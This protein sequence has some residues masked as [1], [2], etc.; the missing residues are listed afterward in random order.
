M[1]SFLN[2]EKMIIGLTGKKQH[3]KDTV[4]D[5]LVENGFLKLSFADPLKKI[6]QQ[7]FSL[8][9]SQLHDPTMKEVVDP[10]WGKS[11][12][13][14]FQEIGTDLFRKHYDDR[15]WIKLLLHEIG[16]H[17]DRNIVVSDARFQD[18]CDALSDLQNSE[19]VH[20][21]KVVRPSMTLQD[22]HA[23]EN[24]ILENYE[25]ICNSGSL[26]EFQAAL[27]ERFKIFKRQ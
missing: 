23:S 27:R 15:I 24:G 21:F 19:E 25:T 20:I 18:E 1:K 6:C 8:D 17:P 13:Q 3:G 14:L 22:D 2:H 26:A 4:A 12:R 10:R 9:E 16:K 5:V 11:P 7:L